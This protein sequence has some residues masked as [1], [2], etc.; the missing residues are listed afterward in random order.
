MVELRWVEKEA[1]AAETGVPLLLGRVEGEGEHV[2]DVPVYTSVEGFAS[3]T[4]T[5][6][7]STLA[8]WPP[9]TTMMA[10]AARRG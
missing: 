2:Q 8:P 10:A 7:L 4:H 5:S 1:A 9:T 6:G 3:N